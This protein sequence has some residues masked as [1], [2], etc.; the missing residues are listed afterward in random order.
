M[1]AH[2]MA[3]TDAQ[4]EHR[5]TAAQDALRAIDDARAERQDAVMAARKAGWSKYR[6]AKVLGVAGPT[7]DSI[8]A[9]AERA[10]GVSAED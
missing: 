1:Y 9:T 7:V 4:I 6:I 2:P 5:L 3:D 8:I 10:S